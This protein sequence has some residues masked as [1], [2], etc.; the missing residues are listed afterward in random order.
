MLYD[1]CRYTG[2]A[3]LRSLNN[4]SFIPLVCSGGVKEKC[5]TT[6]RTTT[7]ISEKIDSGGNCRTTSTST[8]AGADD[9][10][11]NRDNGSS[12]V[13]EHSQSGC[14]GT[15]G[16]GVNVST[17]VG[18]YRSIVDVNVVTD[19]AGRTV[20]NIKTSVCATPKGRESPHSKTSAKVEKVKTFY[21]D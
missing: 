18:D 11:I 12:S 2:N 20:T 9:V 6:T 13:G 7:T 4:G 3:Y 5:T 16:T 10:D 14:T 17:P 15:A 21:T 1:V 19:A 8:T